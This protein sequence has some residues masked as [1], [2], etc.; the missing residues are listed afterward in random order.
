MPGKEYPPEELPKHDQLADEDDEL[1][2]DR[3]RFGSMADYAS[4]DE[5]ETVPYDPDADPFLLE[6]E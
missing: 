3:D 1:G 4:D 5:P 6:G 2:W